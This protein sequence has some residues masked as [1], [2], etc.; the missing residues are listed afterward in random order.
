MVETLFS[1]FHDKVKRAVSFS[2]VPTVIT[3]D[4][5]YQEG[6]ADILPILDEMVDTLILPGSGIDGLENIEEL[7]TKAEA[8][9]SCLLLVEHYSN[10]DL[11]ILIT[12]LRDAGGRGGDIRNS[13]IAI[14]GM[15]LN[16]DSPIVAAF[17]GAYS[18]IV[19]YPSRYML[20]IEPEKA[21][22][23]QA[24]SNAI[25][26]AAMKALIR[27]KYKGKLILVFPSGTRYRLGN[28]E[29]KKGLR[30][31][32]SYIRSFDYMC[33]VALNGQILHVNESDMMND[34][35]NKDIVRVTVGPVINCRDF[36]EKAIDTASDDE[37][38]KQAVADAIMNEL[39]TM[40]IAAE[41]KRKK[42]LG[43]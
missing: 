16:E 37:D 6:N 11:S 32:D 13:I 4:N 41:E 2:K 26:R 17:A 8:G 34:V 31:M 7:Y 1:T 14:S 30:E 42:L 40:H 35:V 39:E 15:K 5:V 10:L 19:I 9:K 38:K 43:Q 29:T 3:E 12:L 33:C 27:H 36:R 22:V 24:R 25:N 23:E 28:P 18:R 20:D 21:K